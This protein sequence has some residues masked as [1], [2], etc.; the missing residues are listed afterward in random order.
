MQAQQRYI[1]GYH[2]PIHRAIWQRILT[3]GAPRMWSGVWLLLCLM[4]TAWSF[5]IFEARV[6][7]VPMVLWGIGQASLKA[8]TRWDPQWDQVAKAKFRYRSYYEAG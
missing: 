1:E 2:A 4:A 3:W 6:Y 8:L 5:V 7:F